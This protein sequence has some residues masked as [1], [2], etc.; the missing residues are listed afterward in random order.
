MPTL[1][2]RERIKKVLKR[3]VVMT[4]QVLLKLELVELHIQNLIYMVS[5][6]GRFFEV[7]QNRLKLFV[8]NIQ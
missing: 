2:L 1:I 6:Q 8:I 7:N 5:P 4:A 3:A